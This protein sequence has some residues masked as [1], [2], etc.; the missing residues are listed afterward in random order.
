[1]PTFGSDLYSTEEIIAEPG[2]C[3]LTSVTGIAPVTFEN[4]AAYINGWIERLKGDKHVIFY[5]ST[6][7][8]K[9][10]DYI[11]N[12]KPEEA[13]MPEAESVGRGK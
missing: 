6:Q 4:N 5:A 2:T 13:E 11:L 3:Y 9:A 1:M 12:I 8:Q 7:S 10:T